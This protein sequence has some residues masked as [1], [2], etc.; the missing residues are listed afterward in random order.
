MADDG[1]EALV[2]IGRVAK[3]RGVR[4]EAHLVPMTDFPE[5]FA[6]LDT[7]ALEKHDHTR[8]TV[9]VSYVKAYGS[10]L[11]IKFGGYNTPESVARLKGGDLLGEISG[12][13]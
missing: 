3:P 1:G 9:R 7:V 4:G 8:L 6:E 11:A 5:R 13:R 12:C 10:R 2:T